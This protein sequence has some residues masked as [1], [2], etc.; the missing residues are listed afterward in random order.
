LV[1]GKRFELSLIAGYGSY[2]QLFGG[3]E[4]EH[5]NLWGVGHNTRLEFI[6]SFR[7][8]VGTYTYTIPEFLAPHVN[9]FGAVDGFR[10]EELTFDRQELKFSLGARR[11]FVRSGQQV[12]LRYSYQFLDAQT[13][14]AG[15]DQT[16]AAAIIGDW[17]LDRRDNPL[18]PRDGYRLYGN[19]EYATPAL[20][21]NAEYVRLELG[22][23]YHK[24]FSRGLTLHLGLVHGI[25]ASPDRVDRLPFN[26]RFFPGGENSVRGYQ[27]GGASP[28]DAN[29]NQVGA[30]SVL[31]WNAEL[32]QNVTRTFSVVGFVDGAGITPVIESW[33]LDEVLWSVGAGIRWNSVIGPVR[34]EYGYNLNPR[35]ADPDGTLHFS[36]GFPF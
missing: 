27:R 24:P 18:L 22:G 15:D 3:I 19:L 9:L 30:E 33:P 2:D 4:F 28:V 25:V 20:G 1:E 8:T 11:Q 12:G 23:S 14:A 21:G 34:L 13:A 32:E 36:I 10:R 26:K 31:Q 17:Q 7:S 16:R 5:F 35:P 29:G 6:Q